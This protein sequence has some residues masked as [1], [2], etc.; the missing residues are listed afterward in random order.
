MQSLYSEQRTWLHRPPAGWKLLLLAIFSTSLFLTERMDVLVLGAAL[1]A[2]GWVS[3]GRAGWVARK[4]L[5]LLVVACL[6]IVGFHTLMHQA[7]LGVSSA[8]R[9]FSTALMGA[10][11]TLTTRYTDVLDV[12]EWLLSPLSRIGIRVDRLALQLALM[13]RFIEHFFVLWQRLDDA[14]R[15]RTGQHGGWR[16]LAPLTLQMLQ[17]AT[18]VADTLE[19]RL[20]K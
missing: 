1:C 5:M 19:V 14:H 8:L 9:L 4:L 15:V 17:S 12:L 16:L 20:G 10:A 7:M 3:L 13:L 11:F 18:R 2:L 6:L